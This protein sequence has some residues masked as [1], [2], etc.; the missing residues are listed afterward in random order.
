MIE[1]K[2]P[3]SDAAAPVAQIAGERLGPLR[4]VGRIVLVG[5]VRTT[6]GPVAVD[7]RV[8]VV[9]GRHLV[10]VADIAMPGDCRAVLAHF[11]IFQGRDG[12]APEIV[13]VVDH[14]D[15]RVHLGVAQSG[16][17]MPLH[18][19]DFVFLRATSKRACDRPGRC[20][21]RC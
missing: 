18:E 9:H 2:V 11:G 16:T 17:K 15:L 19:V 12:A 8:R 7:F 1:R 21:L 6:F 3:R 13:V 20:P 14:P 10:S 5:H 4:P